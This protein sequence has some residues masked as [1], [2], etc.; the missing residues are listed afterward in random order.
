[1]PITNT[2]IQNLVQIIKQKIN[3]TTNKTNVT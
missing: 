1:M 3:I 2:I